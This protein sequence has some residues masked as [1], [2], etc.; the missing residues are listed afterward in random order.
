MIMKKY[1][2][3]A[4]SVALFGMTSC[5]ED[6]LDE[7]NKNYKYPAANVVPAHL[8]ITDAIMQQHSTQL[9]AIIPSTS[10]LLPSSR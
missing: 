9:Q 5:S 2:V 4:M 8:Q 10:L 6:Q 3:M 1:I 7:V